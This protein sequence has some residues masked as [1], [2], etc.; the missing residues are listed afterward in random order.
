MFSTPSKYKKGYY[1]QRSMKNKW[2]FRLLDKALKE[3]LGTK[4]VKF[5]EMSVLFKIY[6][7][8]CIVVYKESQL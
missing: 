5:Y 2:L 6:L 4:K 7:L 3:Y 8:S 1:K